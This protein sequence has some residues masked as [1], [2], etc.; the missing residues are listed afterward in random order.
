MQQMHFAMC[1]KPNPQNTQCLITFW[2][3]GKCKAVGLEN[4][5]V[6]A[7]DVFEMRC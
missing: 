3:K 5:S 4:I 6:V 1:T 7:S 2:G